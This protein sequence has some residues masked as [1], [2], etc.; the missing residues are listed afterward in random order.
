MIPIYEDVDRTRLIADKRRL[1]SANLF[2]IIAYTDANPNIKK[3]LRDC[4]Y[5]DCFDTLSCGWIIYAIRPEYGK[6]VSFSARD[7][8]DNLPRFEYNYDFLADFGINTSESFPMLIVCALAENES[9]EAI[10]IPLDDSAFDE[11]AKN[12]I[13][14][15][16]DVTKVLSCIDDGYK[17]STNVLREVEREM[18]ARRAK[19]SLKKASKAFVEF[20]SLVASAKGLV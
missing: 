10:R 16:K 14:I 19:I 12:L 7:D 1:G 13:E 5:W 6:R 2:G 17:S 18:S 20:F 9:V 4:D 8:S 3:L 15:V 11:A